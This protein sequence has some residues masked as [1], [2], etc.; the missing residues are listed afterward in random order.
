MRAHT[1][2]PLQ[3]VHATFIRKKV[4]SPL[5]FI[6]NRLQVH[7]TSHAFQ[8]KVTAH[9]EGEAA[10]TKHTKS[11]TFTHRFKEWFVLFFK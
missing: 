3:T 6:K 5:L 7:K 9:E 1:F 4:T 2:S 11:K 8:F 10:F